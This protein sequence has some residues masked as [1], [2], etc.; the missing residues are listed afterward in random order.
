M[1]LTAGPGRLM[2]RSAPRPY[3]A[4]SPARVV[5]ALPH[6]AAAHC[7]AAA[8]ARRRISRVRRAHAG[9]PATP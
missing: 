9:D 5:A 4:G 3:S 6:R 7:P 2:K 1:T 8:A